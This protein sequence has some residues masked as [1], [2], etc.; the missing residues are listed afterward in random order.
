MVGLRAN[1]SV[2]FASR[3]ALAADFQPGILPGIPSH[4]LGDMESR[5][6][7]NQARVP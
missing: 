5:K 1:A 7:C 3:A 4:N 2:I 6:A